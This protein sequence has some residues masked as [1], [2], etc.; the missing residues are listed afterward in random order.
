MYQEQV[1][2]QQENQ[3][4][5]ALEV[6]T[7]K[8]A[9]EKSQIE[10]GTWKAEAS[11]IRKISFDVKVDRQVSATAQR[12]FDELVAYESKIISD[13]ERVKVGT[14][15]KKEEI[16][17]NEG[18]WIREQSYFATIQKDPSFQKFD[19]K[20]REDIQQKL[21]A[22]GM[23]NL[24]GGF[25]EGH[26]GGFGNN[27][28]REQD[29]SKEEGAR[30]RARTILGLGSAVTYEDAKKAYRKFMMQN[31][32]DRNQNGVSKRVEE[33]IR[34]LTQVWPSL[35]ENLKRKAVTT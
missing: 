14:E 19:S 27:N 6:L 2:A 18:K 26:D 9:T 35:E 33:Q 22:L 21:V 8:F 25:T 29:L 17:A 11:Y 31:H 3:K 30:R 15:Y 13:K 23:M 24:S 12:M 7:E 1:R 4:Q 16:L 10:G 28:N 34:E 32:P 5:E 20:L